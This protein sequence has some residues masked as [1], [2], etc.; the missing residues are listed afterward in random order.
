MPL[1]LLL[2]SSSIGPAHVLGISK[3]TLDRLS[4]SD[5][6]VAAVQYFCIR[7]HRGPFYT[8]TAWIRYYTILVRHEL[9]SNDDQTTHRLSPG[10]GVFLPLPTRARALTTLHKTP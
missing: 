10:E 7:V 8:S 9:A 3:Y 1:S 6:V 4:L 5:T 2:T